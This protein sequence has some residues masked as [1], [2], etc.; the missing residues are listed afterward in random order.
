MLFALLLLAGGLRLRLGGIA[1][2]LALTRLLALKGAEV[3]FA[4]GADGARLVGARVV[5]MPRRPAMAALGAAWRM[6]LVPASPQLLGL[7]LS[8][9]VMDTTRATTE[10]GWTPTVDALAAVEEVIEAMRESA[11]GQTPPLRTDAGG[12]LREQEVASGVGERGGVT[13]DDR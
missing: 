11:G 7:A 4:D 10:L 13:S 9:P 3:G 5:R 6:H 12:R 2:L 8:I 1:R